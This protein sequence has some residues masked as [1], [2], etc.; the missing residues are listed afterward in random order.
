M[1]IIFQVVRLE[2]EIGVIVFL[3]D[4]A[5]GDRGSQRDQPEPT[6]VHRRFRSVELGDAA[7]R[8]KG[9]RNLTTD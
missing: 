6:R 3:D 9:P 8:H 1:V 4:R 5:A 2:L 7:I